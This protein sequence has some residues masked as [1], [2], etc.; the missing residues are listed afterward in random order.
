MFDVSDLR[1]GNLP[2]FMLDSTTYPIYEAIVEI[3][4]PWRYVVI[5]QQNFMQRSEHRHGEPHYDSSGSRVLLSSSELR[6]EVLV[7]CSIQA[8]SPSLT[9]FRRGLYAP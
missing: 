7:V 8:Y 6:L 3:S 4:V 2:A 1:P 9:C 5:D